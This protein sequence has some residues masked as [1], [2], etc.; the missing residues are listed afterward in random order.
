MTALTKAPKAG[1][2][3]GRTLT[4]AEAKRLLKALEDNRLGLL[5][6]VM[7]APETKGKTLE[8]LEGILTRPKP[9]LGS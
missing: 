4:P 1:Q 6:I 8:E 3:E 5:F 7:L 9:A 2:A